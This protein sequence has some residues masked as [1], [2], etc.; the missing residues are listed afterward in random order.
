MHSPKFVDKYFS[1]VNEDFQINQMVSRSS[2]K[3]NSLRIQQIPSG[4]LCQMSDYCYG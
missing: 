2:I 3:A 1:K 4:A